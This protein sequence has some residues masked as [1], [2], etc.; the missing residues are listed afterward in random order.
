M[1]YCPEKYQKNII[2]DINKEIL[3]MKG[4]LKEHDAKVSLAKFLRANIGLTT[5]LIS[6][7]NLA[8]YQEITLKAFLNRN[9]NLC[10]FG[11]GCGKCLTY[12]KHS[13]VYTK[14]HGPINLVDLIPDLKFDEE[15]WIDIPEIDLWNGEKWVKT[16]KVLLQPKIKTRYIKAVKKDIRLAG[17]VNHMI[18]IFDRD[19][20]DI[21]WKKF[22][23]IKHGDVLVNPITPP[24]G[25]TTNFDI[26]KYQKLADAYAN[27][28]DPDYI[29]EDLAK[30]FDLPKDLKDLDLPANIKSNPYLLKEFII[31]YL[32]KLIIPAKSGIGMWI[33]NFNLMYKIRAYLLTNG[34]IPR[35]TSKKKTNGVDIYKLIYM[36]RDAERLLH[37]LGVHEDVKFRKYL[38]K[39]DKSYSLKHPNKYSICNPSKYLKSLW[40]TIPIEKRK[41]AEGVLPDRAKFFKNCG[42][43]VDYESA[44]EYY[45]KLEYHDLLEYFPNFKKCIE[46]SYSYEIVSRVVDMVDTDCI[47]FNVPDGEKYWANGLVNHNSFLASIFCFLQCIFVP[48]S[49]IL[50]AGPTFRTARNIFTE[51]EKIVK[52]PEAA[53]LQQAFHREPSKRNDL[54]EWEIN[55][56]TIR[57]IPL[58]GEKIRGFRANVLVLDEFLLLQKDIVKNVL[59]PF[60]TSPADLGK[61]IK[62]REMEDRAIREGRMKE[63]DREMFPNTSKMICLSSASY[64][65]ENL[66]TTYKDWKANIEMTEAEELAELKKNDFDFKNNAKPTY[67]ISQ[68]GYNGIPEYMMD[69]TII[70]EAKSGG[71]SDPSFLREYCA[72]FT[73]GSD[74]Y[75]SMVKMEENTVKYGEKPCVQLKAEKDKK[76]IISIDPSFSD[77]SASDFFSICVIMCEP[78]FSSPTVVH[79]YSVPQADFKQMHKY[80]YYVYK[81]FNPE[82]VIIDNAGWN[83]IDSANES[84]LFLESNLNIKF[85]EFDACKEGEE[86]TKELINFQ[87]YHNRTANIVAVKQYFHPDF[88]RKSNEHLKYM[89]D[90]KRMNFASGLCLHDEEYTRALNNFTDKTKPE[91]ERFAL[92]NYVKYK[93]VT[94]M[95]DDL[96]DWILHTKKQTALIE[97]KT[98]PSGT[99][100]FDLPKNLKK[101][102]AKDRARKD[103]YTTLLL[104]MWGA[105]IMSDV[106]N[107]PKENIETTFTPKLI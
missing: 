29:T 65:F 76:Y 79:G 74:S 45:K 83:F 59:M 14:Q 95:I 63:E 5:E 13:V 39:F 49:K 53:L 91:S 23:E 18:Q 35:F 104:G 41:M 11:R 25:K 17:S 38:K 68:I 69:P 37:F 107:R 97:V 100:S 54:F 43:M 57:A 47:D 61:R 2:T 51:L 44:Y 30:E 71:E 75:F 20:Y 24:E 82:L 26:E 86:Y 10:V 22:S 88:I 73:D 70:S 92:R 99:Q 8:P 3:A 93:D 103:N 81:Y 89:I 33:P 106:F 40:T 67:F 84:E 36:Y 6:G 58:N 1:W 12:T 32:K 56:G 102:K 80:F 52:K 27:Y 90:Y 77:S 46:S 55:G 16:S 66:Y 98:T 19:K 15:K 9:F 42:P 34:I 31:V 28:L 101:S 85:I 72:Q 50:I 64:T 62:T 7:V 60:L 87:Q 78:D 94:E 48:N 4:E 105:K 96:D 21:I